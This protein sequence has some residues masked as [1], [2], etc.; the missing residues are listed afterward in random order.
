MRTGSL[1]IES[2]GEGRGGDLALVHGWGL[3]KAVWQPVIAALSQ[4]F[5]LHLVDLPGY[6]AFDETTLATSA[7]FTPTAQALVDRL[8][9]GT[10]LCGWSLGG[11]LAL[12][13]TLLAPRHFNRLILVG[14]S[15]CFAQ[16]ADWRCA[17]PPALLD[18]FGNAV[19]SDAPLALRRFVALLNQGDASA[20]AITGRLAKLAATPPAGATLAQGLAWLREIDLRQAL[21][22]AALALPALLIHGRCD[23]MIPYAAAEWLHGELPISR[24]EIFDAAA[25]APF[26]SD[27]ERFADLTADFCHAP[28]AD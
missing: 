10:A 7:G 13:A 4:R 20:R 26:L 2:L 28:V 21:Q 22:S 16:R 1:Q 24:I 8:P 14:A 3:G 23:T 19:A 17:Q 6:G 11:L 5:R 9:A 15:P 12:Q 25:H 18:A 27:P